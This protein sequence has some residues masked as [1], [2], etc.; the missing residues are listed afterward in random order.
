MWRVAQELDLSQSDPLI[1]HSD[2]LPENARIE[3]MNVLYLAYQPAVLLGGALLGGTFVFS[4]MY[5]LNVFFAYPHLF[6]NFGFGTAHGVFLGPALGGVYILYRAFS[7]YIINVNIL[8]PDGMDGY[9]EIGDTIV[10]RTI[11]GI[12]FI[13]LDFII[14][15]SVAFTGYTEFQIVV[16][17]LYVTVPVAF[18]IT[19]FS[20]TF[21]IRQ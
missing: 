20:M 12:L 14:L 6:L 8:D 4:V 18:L 15:S 7:R 10:T 1:H 19:A 21:I 3:L 2:I 9:R 5:V 16:S 17:S 13:T 11:S